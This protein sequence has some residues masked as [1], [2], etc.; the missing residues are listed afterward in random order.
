MSPSGTGYHVIV[1]GSIPGD[2]SRRGSV[3]MYKRARFFTVTGEHVESTP[4]RVGERVGALETVDNEY[5]AG[6]VAQEENKTVIGPDS[7][8]ETK[9]NQSGTLEDA[10]LLEAVMD[11]KE[12]MLHEAGTSFRL[13]DSRRPIV[14]R[15]VSKGVCSSCGNSPARVNNRLG[16]SRV[17]RDE[18]SSLSGRRASSH[19]STRVNGCGSGP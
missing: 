4:S 14:A 8:T 19:W 2:R 9:H 10:D 3:E 16:C 1:R 5:I 13:T 15:S 12:E 7:T 6:S 18:R 17:R 11:T